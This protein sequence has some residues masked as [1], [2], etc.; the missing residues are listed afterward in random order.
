M[1]DLDWRTSIEIASTYG[2]ITEGMADRW[3]LL[4]DIQSLDPVPKIV[5]YCN[6]PRVCPS[7]PQLPRGRYNQTF[8]GH[9][10]RVGRSKK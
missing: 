7:N 2:T 8:K 1:T 9:L 5:R 10:F 6:H 3:L 4:Q